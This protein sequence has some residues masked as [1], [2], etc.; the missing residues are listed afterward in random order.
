[1]SRYGTFASVYRNDG[2]GMFTDIHAGLP[3]VDSGSGAWGD[4]D[5]DG[6]LDILL[7]GSSDVENGPTLPVCIATTAEAFANVNDIGLTQIWASSAAWGDYD[8]DDD[9]DLVLVGRFS[10]SDSFAGIY[11]N[12]PCAQLSISKQVTPTSGIEYNDIVT[13]TVIMG[14]TGYTT[15]NAVCTDKLPAQMDFAGWAGDTHGATNRQ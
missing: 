3:G 1:M 14:N 4:Y 2:N 6:D 13:Y 15:T 7:A 12:E 5:G 9:L 8:N 10:T 11:R